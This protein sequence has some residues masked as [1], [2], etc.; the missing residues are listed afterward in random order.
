MTQEEQKNFTRIIKNLNQYQNF[1]QF[2]GLYDFDILDFS[3]QDIKRII[4]AMNNCDLVN[5]NDKQWQQD[6]KDLIKYINNWC[7]VFRCYSL[8]IE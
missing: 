1:F 7:V 3:K 8:Y 2:I 4:N 5:K 6:K